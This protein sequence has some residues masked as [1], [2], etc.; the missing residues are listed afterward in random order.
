MAEISHLQVRQTFCE[1]EAAYKRFGN[2][3]V[4]ETAVSQTVAVRPDLAVL[5]FIAGSTTKILV[6]RMENRC[7]SR[8]TVRKA[9]K[10]RLYLIPEGVRKKVPQ[11]T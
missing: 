5:T 1:A 7:I 2:V 3:A 9:K 4:A 8:G 10:Q 11:Q 6:A